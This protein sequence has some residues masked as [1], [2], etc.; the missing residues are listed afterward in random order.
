MN[1]KTQKCHQHHNLSEQIYLKH[2]R[3][4]NQNF[5]HLKIFYGKLNRLNLKTRSYMKLLVFSQ[6]AS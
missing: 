5:L 4:Q 3:Y 6:E 1:L 2:I